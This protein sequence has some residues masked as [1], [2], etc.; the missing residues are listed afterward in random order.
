MTW[1]GNLKRSVKDL[2]LYSM[3]FFPPFFLFPS[4][5]NQRVVYLKFVVFWSLQ[6]KETVGLENREV[7]RYVARMEERDRR[8]EEL[9]TRAPLTKME[10]KREKYLKKSR[11]GYIDSI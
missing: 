10:K 6:I 8:E 11:Y 9:F 4:L 7:A 1:L 3:F 5:N 2:L